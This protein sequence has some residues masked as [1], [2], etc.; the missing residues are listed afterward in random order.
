MLE[1]KQQLWHNLVHAGI[2]NTVLMSEEIHIRSITAFKHI[3]FERDKCNSN[4]MI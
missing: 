3:N 1:R 2:G 4:I